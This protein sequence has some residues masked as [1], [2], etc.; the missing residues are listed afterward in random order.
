MALE[1]E[2]AQEPTPAPPAAA[3]STVALSALEPKVRHQRAV[4]DRRALSAEVADA[5]QRYVVSP[6]RSPLS[7]SRT[8]IVSRV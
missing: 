4:I 2:I 6:S 3:P 1:I 8:G 5:W 7:A